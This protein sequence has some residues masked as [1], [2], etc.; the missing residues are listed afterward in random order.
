MKTPRDVINHWTSKIVVNS[1]R[2]RGLGAIYKFIIQ[3]E[4]GG[5]WLLHCSDIVHV[6]EHD[7]EADCTVTVSSRDFVSLGSGSMNPQIAYMMG[8][9]KVSGNKSLA[10]KLSAVL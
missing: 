2:F 8:K 7:G 5:V 3:G 4:G 9:L 1:D 6:D 10:L